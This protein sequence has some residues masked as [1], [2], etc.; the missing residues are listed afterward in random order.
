M[1]PFSISPPLAINN[2]IDSSVS[3][4]NIF[5]NGMSINTQESG[6]LSVISLQP[7]K[8]YQYADFDVFSHSLSCSNHSSRSGFS[9]YT[10][11]MAG[12]YLSEAHSLLSV[13]YTHL[14]AHE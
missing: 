3:G 2:I 7:L 9:K 13:S 4:E 12:G 5:F 6:F 1:T 11:R 8:E 10:T 14:R